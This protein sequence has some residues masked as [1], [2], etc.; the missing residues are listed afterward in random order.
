MKIK[1]GQKIYDGKKEPI[2][3][4]LTN[5]DKENIKNMA[6][7]ATKYC[8]YPDSISPIKIKEFMKTEDLENKS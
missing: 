6:P 8:V 2:M 1:I 7:S 3:I 5:R 4:I